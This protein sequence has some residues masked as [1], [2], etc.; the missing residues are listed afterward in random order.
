MD[1]LPEV[2][3]CSLNINGISEA[4]KLS[5]AI[6]SCLKLSS[7]SKIICC[8]QECKVDQLNHLH[9]KI[10][11]YYK[12]KHVYTPAERHAGGL[13]MAFSTDLDIKLLKESKHVQCFEMSHTLKIYNFYCRTDEWKISSQSLSNILGSTIS[14]SKTEKILLCGDFNSFENRTDTSSEKILRNDTRFYMHRF[15]TEKILK[16]Y[17]LIDTAKVA[18]NKEY[19]HRDKRT[20]T[21]SRIDY[22]YTNFPQMSFDFQVID[23]VLSDHKLLCV[24][25]F[26][27]IEKR[28]QSYWKL[29]DE[30]LE[31]ERKKIK[32]FL[33]NMNQDTTAS[34]HDLRKARL[35]NYLRFL[36]INHASNQGKVDK[37]LQQKLNA[38]CSASE[39]KKIQNRIIRRTEHKAW[40]KIKRIKRF[41]RDVNEGDSAAL[42]KLLC[43]NNPTNNITQIEREDKSNTIDADEIMKEFT[44]KYK[45]IYKNQGVN[46]TNQKT[47]I[48]F[49]SKNKSLT[50]VEKNSLKSPIT[51]GEVEKAIDKLNINS[52]PG[53]DGL[54]SALYKKFKTYF[55]FSICNTIN[56][57]SVDGVPNS[58][59][60]AVI[61]LLPKKPAP[62]MVDDYRPISLINTDQKI[63]SHVIA[64]R[65]KSVLD[66]VIESAQNA[67]LSKRQMNTGINFVRMRISK[68]E[69]GECAWS[70]DFSK[71][72]DRLDRNYLWSL[73][74]SMGFPVEIVDLIDKLY[75]NTTSMI[76][77]NGF[78]SAKI[79]IER[80]VRQGDPLSALLFILAIDP[81]LFAIRAS[82]II[83]SKGSKRVS[84]YADDVLCFVDCCSME[85]LEKIVKR[86]CDATQLTINEQKSDILSHQP[87]VNKKKTVQKIVHLGITH[88]IDKKDNGSPIIAQQKIDE[89]AARK[90]SFRAKAINLDI[91]LTS[92]LLFLLRHSKCSLENIEQY[93]KL[94]VNC[95]WGKLS[96]EIRKDILCLPT[97]DGGIGLPNITFKICTAKIMDLKNV[98]FGK[99]KDVED[100]WRKALRGGEAKQDL[101]FLKN[102]GLNWKNINNERLVLAFK[103][104][105]VEI[106]SE[107][108]FKETYKKLILINTDKAIVE[109]RLEKSAARFGVSVNYLLR[110][111]N[112]AWKS[113]TLRPYEKNILYRLIYN[114]LRDKNTI[115]SY[116]KETASCR[117]CRSDLETFEHMIFN[118]SR[119]KSYRQDF[120]YNWSSL[121]SSFESKHMHLGILIIMASWN[122]DPE[123]GVKYVEEML[124]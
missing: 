34:E 120:P 115:A 113:K 38:C 12:L 76:E 82:K 2:M 96:P 52:A 119:F 65:I 105:E 30:I 17:D 71:A 110:I 15:L 51:I 70:L 99:D 13:L 22:I 36:C 101:K 58:L 18:N 10:L 5:H 14:K 6:D 72:F 109:K 91:F 54:T 83:K 9:L 123:L 43:R 85:Y 42:K 106:R 49:Y 37:D 28:G 8:L 78:L 24:K 40:Q 112:C 53:P 23:F 87:V 111:L 100:E 11:E 50:E 62:K 74:K 102:C 94:F 92:K 68:M 44:A 95:I 16:V 4:T 90:M 45:N 114:G 108:S 29:N 33:D 97:E 19:T 32:T 56:S 39:K 98:L 31:I 48:D 64:A 118:C 86:F 59:Y 35:R 25:T 103:G 80:G 1:V 84:A 122:E 69:E 61:K 67:Y 104:Q 89:I 7:G 117:F 116:K 57:L 26:Q 3:F 81:L 20:N 63:I 75:M 21:S 46:L 41:Y 77:I 73:M 66:R 79:K 60:L 88:R 124:S 121:L 107:T 47:F 55:S 93:Q 27:S